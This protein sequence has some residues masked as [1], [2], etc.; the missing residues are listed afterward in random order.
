MI[1][2]LFVRTSHGISK[3]GTKMGKYKRSKPQM[4][5]FHEHRNTTVPVRVKIGFICA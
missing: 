2:S 4:F 1:S 3:H 5:K